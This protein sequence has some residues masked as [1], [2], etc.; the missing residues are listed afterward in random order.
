MTEQFPTHY[1]DDFVGGEM[2]QRGT[3][4][5]SGTIDIEVDPDTKE[6][7]AV[8]FRCLNLPYRVFMHKATAVIQPGTFVTAVEYLEAT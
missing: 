6:V 7:T 8:W 3:I 4:H 5:G 1:G 2:A